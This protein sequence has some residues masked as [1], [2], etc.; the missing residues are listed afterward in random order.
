MA[1]RIGRLIVALVVGPIVALA[2]AGASSTS[3]S[4]E[5]AALVDRGRYLVKIAGCNDCHTPRYAETGGAV[6]E[7]EW[8]TGAAVGWRGPWGTT[9]PINLRLHMS[10][11]S[12]QQWLV[13]ARAVRSRPP[14]PWFAL[15][16]MSDRDL[17]AIYRFVR[18]LGARGEPAPPYLPPDRV[19]PMPFVQ[20]P[21]PK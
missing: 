5:P 12:E 3:V 13:D 15:R 10:A 4:S 7:A 17:R 11:L 8:L 2:H 14:M 1:H 20:F 16:D 21:P 18:A 6:P 9:Y 19:P